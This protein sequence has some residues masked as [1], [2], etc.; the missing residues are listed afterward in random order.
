MLST[1][2]PSALSRWAWGV[3]PNQANHQNNIY[4]R[5]SSKKHEKNLA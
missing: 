1:G 4:L 3:M 2:N 5:F